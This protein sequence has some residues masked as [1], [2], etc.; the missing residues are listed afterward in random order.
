MWREIHTSP[1]G[2]SP[3]PPLKYWQQLKQHISWPGKCSCWSKMVGSV[4]T[5]ICWVSDSSLETLA[6]FSQKNR[7]ELGVRL[8][9][10]YILN[11]PFAWWNRLCLEFYSRL[12]KSCNKQAEQWK[13]TI[14]LLCLNQ[15]EGHTEAGKIIKFI[16]GKSIVV[17]HC[18][19]FLLQDFRNL[20]YEH[21]RSKALFLKFGTLVVM[22]VP[23]VSRFH[24][25]T[26][27]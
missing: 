20:L 13:T 24:Q 17:F 6:S 15:D 11:S 8:R 19:A 23:C 10:S 21:S 14:D 27:Q 26:K 12:Q 5:K 22:E 4:S 18:S 2:S 16:H 3:S 9:R 25:R 7:K 1:K